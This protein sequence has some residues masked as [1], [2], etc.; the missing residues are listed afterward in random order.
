M[1]G[2]DQAPIDDAAA[3]DAPPHIPELLRQQV[4]RLDGSETN[5]SAFHGYGKITEAVDDALPEDVQDGSSVGASELPLRAPNG[6]RGSP[7]ESLSNPDDTPSIQASVSSQILRDE[8]DPD[9]PPDPW[10]VVRWTKLRQ[11]TGQAFSEVG[12]RNFGKP[13]CMAVSAA[14]ALGTSKGVILLFDYRQTLKCIIGPGT[15]AVESGA[16]T[17]LAISADHSTVAAGHASGHIFTWDI[18]KSARPFLHISPL[19][20]SQLRDRKV[21]GHVAGVAILHLG[22]LGTRHTALASAD[23]RGMAFSHLATRGLGA[24]GRTIKTQRVLGRYPDDLAT[25]GRPRKPSSVLAFSPLPLGD[26]EQVT[27]TMGLVAILTPYL[28]VIVSATP[29]AQTQH[30]AA[31]HKEVAAHGALSGCLAW[32]P[33]VKL[34]V[35]DPKTSR[36]VSLAKLVYCWSN[37]LTVLDVDE[38]EPKD[39]AQS[40]GPPSL[41]FRPRSRWKAEESI[42]AVQWLGRSVL[43]VLTITQ[44]LIILEDGGLRM[45]DSFDLLQKQI[46]HLDVFSRQLQMLVEPADGED[47]SMH[48]VV[49]DAFYNSFRAFK[50]RMFLLGFDDVSVGTL[51]NWAERLT[52]LMENGDFVGAVELAIAYYNG[53]GDT[54]TVGLPEDSMARHAAVE[55]KLS[56]TMSTAIGHAFG[57]EHQAD[58]SLGTAELH[59]LASA[60]FV[61]SV[62]MDATDFLFDEVFEA[63]ETGDPEGVFL[64][65]LE[66]YILDGRIISVP[67]TVVKALITHYSAGGLEGRLEEM[68][69]QLDTSSMDIDQITSL[70]KQHN[71]FDALV[72]VWN[73][74]IGDYVTPLVDLLSLVVRGADEPTHLAGAMKIFPYLAYTF[75]SRVYPSGAALDEEVASRAKADLY[76]FILS[77]KTVDWP[78]GSGKPLLTRGKQEVEPSYPYLRLILDF[79]APSFMGAL[80]EAFE[81]PFL[82]GAPDR[83]VNGSSEQTGSREGDSGRSVNRQYIVS[84]L[85]EVMSNDFPPEDTIYL[86]MFIARNLPK[87]PQFI[88]LSGTSLHKIIVGLCQYSQDD[89][90]DDR[91][92]SVEYL[93]S[94]YRPPDMDS[95]IPL[96]TKAGFYRVLKATY[97]ADRQYAKLLQTY[98]EDRENQELVFDCIGDCLRARAGLGEKQIRDVRQVVRE[99]ARELAMID[100][101]MTAKTLE[102]HAP[103]LHEEVVSAL[104]DDPHAQYLYLRAILE[105]DEGVARRRSDGSSAELYIRLMCEYNPSHVADYIELVQA[106]DLRLEEVLPAMESSGV[107]DAAVVLMA[108]EGQVRDAM[109]RLTNHLGMLEAALLGLLDGADVP[110]KKNNEEAV[111]EILGALRKYTFV[112]IWLC[113]GQMKLQKTMQ[114]KQ[115]G[116]GPAS[117]K[118]ELSPEEDLWLE[119]IDA[120]VRITKNASH[121]HQTSSITGAQDPSPETSALRTLVQQTFT[122]LLTTTGSSAGSS[123]P[124]SSPSPSFLRIL[125]AFLTR[126]SLSSPSLSD[127]RSVLASIFSAYAYEESL[128]AL[129]TRLLDKDLFVHVAHAT[130]ARQRGWRPLGQQCEGCGRRVWGPGAGGRVWEAWKV[131]EGSRQSGSRAKT[132]E[133]TEANE[134]GKGRA[135]PAPATTVPTAAEDE[136]QDQQSKDEDLGPLVVFSCRHLFHKVCLERLLRP[137]G[138]G[139]GEGEGEGVT[140][141]CVVCK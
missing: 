56:S 129:A 38:Q 9:T 134:R 96:F 19:A 98:F 48:G 137:D 43:G 6:Q 2:T 71:L 34:K 70:C 87:F 126:A 40:D 138:Q 8:V 79:D 42:V 53:E 133:G 124:T 7:A 62:A 24:A 112:G 23:D 89:I 90:A 31:R 101:I 116:K 54:L 1:A 95:L 78:T 86:D 16:V 141:R 119:L 12:K 115:A 26:A 73:Q 15:K 110:D 83:L 77:G 63:F 132:L 39:P 10:E 121:R 118:Q 104:E 91:Q 125:R 139:Q 103:D 41:S 45:T 44:Q 25:T 49:A 102:T 88:L 30:K 18:S 140:Y 5:G 65:T 82:N 58:E 36:D 46:Y 131:R 14:I 100:T 69:C 81:D 61:A 123:A 52:A 127:L 64:E 130:Q 117:K 51:S 21:D 97:K 76:S 27:D 113:Q 105:P 122:A 75:T 60:C 94:M 74:A 3:D 57:P 13:T 135:T 17:S 80:N 111:G 28:L 55:V 84:V 59:R 47:S 68:I 128:L 99:H 120:V 93:L 35:R 20:P 136:R 85:L 22:F 50:G 109:E 108:R 37:V 107:V 11:V 72:Y 92:L 106:G 114:K 33:S 32:F 29:I 67:P 66:H 4:E